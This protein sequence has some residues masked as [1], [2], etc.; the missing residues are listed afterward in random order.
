MWHVLMYAE[1]ADDGGGDGI[2]SILRQLDVCLSVYLSRS[3]DDST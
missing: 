2:A 3:R 1:D